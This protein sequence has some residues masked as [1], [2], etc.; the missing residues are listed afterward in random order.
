MLI[1]DKCMKCKFDANERL[2]E[3]EKCKEFNQG[4]Q[5]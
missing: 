1:P 4:N 2:I 3:C 5:E